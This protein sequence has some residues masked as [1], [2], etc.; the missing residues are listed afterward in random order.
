[1]FDKRERMITV[2]KS[3]KTKGT[4]EA[5]VEVPDYKKLI[6]DML[7]DLNESDNKFLIQVYTIVHRHIEKRGR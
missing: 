2:N 3:E 4:R 6:I 5:C 1:M 7:W